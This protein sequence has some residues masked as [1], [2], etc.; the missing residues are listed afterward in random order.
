[1]GTPY[2]SREGKRAAR[3]ANRR[4]GRGGWKKRTPSCNGVDRG[5]APRQDHS[6]RKRADVHLVLH[7]QR[8]WPTS[9]G[10]KADDGSGNT[11][12]CTLRPDD[13]PEAPNAYG[14]GG[15]PWHYRVPQGALARLER[16][17][18]K[19]ARAVLRGLGGS[20]PAWLPGIGET[21]RKVTRPDPTHLECGKLS[22][23]TFCTAKV[24]PHLTVVT[25][26]TA[27]SGVA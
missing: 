25:S 14:E 1:M 8:A 11:D 19:L 15:A 9:Q 23:W 4:A 10:E 7:H 13:G 26:T 16:H 27:Q 2:V 12:W 6:T 17:A 5:C 20:N 24:A 3:Q 18:G 22:F 21:Y